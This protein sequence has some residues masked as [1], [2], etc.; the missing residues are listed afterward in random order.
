M[1]TV[2]LKLRATLAT[3]DKSEKSSYL[4]DSE[5]THHFFCSKSLF[6]TYDIINEQN[7]RS[8]SGNLVAIGKGDIKLS[9]ENFIVE[10]RHAR[11]FSKNIP[12]VRLLT[13]LYIFL[14]SSDLNSE[15]NS[16]KLYNLKK[17]G[18]GDGVG[19]QT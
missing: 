5:T 7:V 15:D 19:N 17:I 13:L 1:F 4:I 6:I 8:A 11:K 18:Q 2:Q 12:L 3:V 14:L 9:F 16:S 10:A